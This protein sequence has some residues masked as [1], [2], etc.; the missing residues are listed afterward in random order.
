MGTDHTSDDYGIDDSLDNIEPLRIESP[1]KASSPKCYAR[2]ENE[3]LNSDAYKEL[4]SYEQLRVRNII[5]NEKIMKALGIG[6]V[7]AYLN[8]YDLVQRK[9]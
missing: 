4:S 1:P 3:M 8:F 7:T 9:S 6:G 2:E 5:E